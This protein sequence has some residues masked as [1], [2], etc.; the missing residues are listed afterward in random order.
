MTALTS[1]AKFFERLL[2]LPVGLGV[3]RPDRHVTE[4][5]TMQN[6]ANG[7]FVKADAKPLLNEIAQI[8]APVAH[9]PVFL[10]IGSLLDDGGKL[11][12]GRAHV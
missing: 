11:Q 6:L 8:D 5:K 12:I 2:N 3:A 1:A 7:P 9:N 10:R 4:A